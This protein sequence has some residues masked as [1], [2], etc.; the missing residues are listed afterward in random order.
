MRRNALIYE[1]MKRK[2]FLK[3][4]NLSFLFELLVKIESK[5]N[6]LLLFTSLFCIFVDSLEL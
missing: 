2:E 4:V 3:N 6:N 5:I 1:L